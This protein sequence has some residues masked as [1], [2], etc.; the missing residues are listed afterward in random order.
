[1]TFLAL[2]E[3]ASAV[4][5]ASGDGTG[6]ITAPGDD[7]GFGHV[8]LLEFGNAVYLGNRW[9]ITASHIGSGPVNFGGTLYDPVLNS[10]MRLR[11]PDD[12]ADTDLL[13]FRLEDDPGLAPLDLSMALPQAGATVLMIGHGANRQPG[14]TYWD[15][16]WNEVAM[17]DAHENSGYKTAS[18]RPKRWGENIIDGY[19]IVETQSD[20]DVESLV[21][22]FDENGLPDEAHAVS[23]DSGGAVFYDNGG[24][25]ELLGIIFGSER[26]PGGGGVAFGHRTFAAVIPSYKPQITAIMAIPEP[27]TIGLALV[28][29]MFAAVVGSRKRATIGRR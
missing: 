25:W 28:A 26:I 19:A 10:A 18:G 9:V 16:D 24:D 29:A 5:I 13:M 12:T 27:G 1:V 22:T 8:G 4:L 11:T 14:L 23:G 7:P 20:G 15:S 21:V 6:N 3:R 17:N 2:P